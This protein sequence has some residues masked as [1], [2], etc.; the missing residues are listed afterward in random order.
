MTE[1]EGMPVSYSSPDNVILRSSSVPLSLLTGVTIMAGTPDTIGVM[2]LLVVVFPGC[3]LWATCGHTVAADTEEQ[4][5][6]TPGKDS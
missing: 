4:D 2:L 1:A 6:G 5:V 3:L